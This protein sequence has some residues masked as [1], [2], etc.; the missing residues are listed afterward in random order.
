MPHLTN[1]LPR[2]NRGAKEFL[3]KVS[4]GLGES[5]HTTAQSW[6]GRRAY[7]TNCEPYRPPGAGMTV[8]NKRY[9]VPSPVGQSGKNTVDVIIPAREEQHD[10]FRLG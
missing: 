7:S 2:R 6:A 1:E 3:R 10:E 9:A 4:Q 5:P 8:A